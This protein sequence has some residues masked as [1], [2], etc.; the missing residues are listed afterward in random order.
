[1]MNVSATKL[2]AILLAILVIPAAVSFGQTTGKISGT[3][4]D[5]ENGE[6]LPGV[7]VVVQGTEQGAATDAEGNFFI[8][9]V[10]PGDYS[11]TASMI[12]YQNITKTGV[13]VSVNHT[14]P[15]NFQLQTEAIAGEAITVEAEREVVRMDESNSTISVTSEEMDGVAS[16]TTIGDFINTQAG[17]QG[18]SVRGGSVD[19]T[20]F[21][22]DGLTVVDNR[23]NQPVVMVNLSAVKELNVIKGGFN[24]EYGNVRSGL[25]NVVTK[26]GTPTAY[27][28]SMDFRMAPAYLKHSGVKVINHQSYYVRPYLDPDVMWEGTDQWPEDLQNR[29]DTFEGW[30]SYAQ[31]LNDNEQD[32]DDI[33]P[34]QA[35]DIFIWRH[36]LEGADELGH[37]TNDYAN[38][39]DWKVDASLGGPVPVVSDALGDLTFFG[40]YREN[41]EMFALPSNRDYFKERN[42]SMKVTS[43]LT[44]NMKL[45]FEGLYGESN[46][47]D[48]TGGY[49]RDV[50]PLDSGTEILDATDLGDPG[51]VDLYMPAARIPVDIYRG[52]GGVSFKHVL[53]SNTFYDFN[54]NYI[55]LQSTTPGFYKIRDTTTVRTFGTYPVDESPYGKWWVSQPTYTWGR[56]HPQHVEGNTWD[57]S[58]TQTLNMKFDFTSQ[59]DRFNQVKLG[60]T[61]TYNDINTDEEHV[62]EG[63]PGNYIERWRVYPWQVGAYIQD[64][65]EF[66]GMIANFGVRLDYANP[67]VEWPT[68]ERY[69]QYFQKQYKDVFMEMAPKEEQK[70]EIEISPRLGISHPISENVKMYFNYGHFYSL[71]PTN[72]LYNIDYG[73]ISRVGGIEFIGNPS[74]DMPKTIAYELGFD[75]DIGRMVLLHLAGYYKD[76]SNQTGEIYYTSYNG[77]VD[78][79]TTE[80]NN[81]QDIRGFEVRIDKKFGDWIRGWVNYD[82]R[83]STSGYVGREHYYQDIREMR[84]Y[85]E[86]NPYQERPLARPIA[87]ANV[88][89]ISPPQW[90]PRLMGRRLFANLGVS[91]LFYYRAGDYFTWDPLLT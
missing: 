61:F 32:W 19:E 80:N 56:L 69:S 88:Q 85:G 52:M 49:A 46:T 75:Y 5:A 62:H 67:N 68:V 77:L 9:N 65:L 66:E 28:G 34:Q 81:Y 70:P 44:Q 42:G 58:R 26:E 18:L 84:R 79:G 43:R 41:W 82:Y 51:S 16:V 72:A 17:V 37:T 23:Q 38:K 63:V 30:N 3:V 48:G 12:G 39:P 24:A 78:Y 60:W 20:K 36:A 53:G 14:T 90:G 47:L 50:N 54:A 29:Y 31:R 6:P 87:R 13:Q 74:A 7:N 45:Q 8:I 64:K 27:H 73:S 55:N 33:T 91:F 76:I 89:I 57:K 35:R 4:T 1:M 83:V 21:M 2:C 59:L 11:V 10:A 40:S 71:A 25:I 22:M 15:V 86:H